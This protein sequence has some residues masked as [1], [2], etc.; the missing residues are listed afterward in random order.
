[1]ELIDQHFKLL[2]DKYELNLLYNKFIVSGY[3]AIISYESFSWA[4]LYFS[5]HLK[6]Q[7]KKLEFYTLCIFGLISIYIGLDRISSYYI[8]ELS[9]KTR[10]AN[11][12]Y[13]NEILYKLPK[14]ELLN[15]DITRYFNTVCA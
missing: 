8:A 10:I 12:K 15:I 1:M 4:L 6:I 7:P 11:Y 9:Q 2:I 13:F 3:C 5:M 14:S